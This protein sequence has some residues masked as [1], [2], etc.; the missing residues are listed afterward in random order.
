MRVDEDTG[1]DAKECRFQF[2]L[3]EEIAAGEE[4][5]FNYGAFV[6][7]SG[8]AESGLL[9]IKIYHGE[10]V[11]CNSDIINNLPYY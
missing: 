4:I 10:K 8:C 9:I 6:I 5:I 3:S 2:F 7:S 11:K 1:C